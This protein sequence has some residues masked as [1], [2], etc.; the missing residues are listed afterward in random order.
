MGFRTLEIGQASE[1]H[2]REGQLEVLS[3]DGLARIPV[4]DLNQ[5]M[6]HIGAICSNKSIFALE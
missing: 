5:I 1:I 3:K 6:V 2:I 4:E